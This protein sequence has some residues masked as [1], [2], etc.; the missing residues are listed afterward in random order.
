MLL[1]EV[2]IE[3]TA[4]WNHVRFLKPSAGINLII[5]PG[6]N[7]FDIVSGKTTITSLVLS[8]SWARL[9]LRSPVSL[10]KIA[11]PVVLKGKSMNMHRQI[12]ISVS[13]EKMIEVVVY[14]LWNLITGNSISFPRDSIA[15]FRNGIKIF[16]D[17]D[18]T[19]EM[20]SCHRKTHKINLPS[21]KFQFSME[22]FNA[23]FR[24]SQLRRFSLFSEKP[25][26]LSNCY[27]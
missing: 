23:I 4:P 13:T 6:D 20:G 1:G 12:E 17:Y 9:S 21:G 15:S 5:C 19:G 16:R 7:R 3:V 10:F 14:F 2:S 25:R 11:D 24:S 26:T 18:T 27:S 8:F 22:I